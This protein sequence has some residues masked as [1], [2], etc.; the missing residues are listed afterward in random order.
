MFYPCLSV[1]LLVDRTTKKLWLDFREIWR[2]ARLWTMEELIKILKVRVRVRDY[3]LCL[4]R[5]LLCGNA[6]W[7][8]A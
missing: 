8:G 1:C 4:A 3:R 6:L 7:P 5:L 2:I